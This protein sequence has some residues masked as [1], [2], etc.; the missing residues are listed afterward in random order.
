MK[1]LYGSL[2]HMDFVIENVLKF[3]DNFISFGTITLDVLRIGVYIYI[4][5][6]NINT[7]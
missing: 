1:I 4:Y 5:Y 7:Y 3:I 2:Y 6:R